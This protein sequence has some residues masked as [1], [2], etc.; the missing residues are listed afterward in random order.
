MKSI[1]T[2]LIIWIKTHQVVA[3]FAGVFLIIVLFFGYK[4]LFGGSSATSYVV[5]T[6]TKGDLVLTVNGTG[7]VEAENQVDLKPQ[8]TT[9]S[10]STITEVDVKQGDSVSTNQLIAVVG[11]ASALT[12][13]T[14][15]KANVE[16][17]QASYD[18]LVNGSTAQSIAVSQSSV[19]SSQASLTNAKQTLLSKISSAYNDVFSVVNSDTNPLFIN[20]NT[21]VLKY[22][23]EGTP[24][25]GHAFC[26]MK[27]TMLS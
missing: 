24:F 15:A 5:G 4:M 22:G 12:Q 2:R 16:S 23:V 20:P 11:N 17:A 21:T 1:Y 10:A 27:D 13:L 7:Q 25:F 8:G 18:K 3:A 19:N 6:V 9:Q 14:Q 26:K